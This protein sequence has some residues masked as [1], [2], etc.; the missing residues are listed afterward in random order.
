MTVVIH[1]TQGIDTPDL[2]ITGSGA[3][4]SGDFSGIPDV[5]DRVVFQTSVVNG[6][7]D[8]N[9]MPNGTNQISAFL[10]FNNSAD[11]NNSSYARIGIDNAAANISSH[12]TGSATLLPL[13]FNVGGAEQM[14]IATDGRVGIGVDPTTLAAGYRFT[15]HGNALFRSQSG[16]EG[17]EIALNLPDNSATGLN[18]DVRTAT[19]SRL[20]SVIPGMN[21]I[22][23]TG[24]GGW[25]SF[26]DAATAHMVINE[27][28]SAASAVRIKKNNPTNYNNSQLELISEAGDVKLGL[29]NQGASASL[30]KC[31]R[32][33]EA[34]HFRNGSDAA[35]VETVASAFTVASDYRLKENVVP[36]QG[37]LA[38]AMQ[39]RPCIFTWKVDGSYGEGFIAHQLQEVVPIA[40]T[41]KKDAMLESGEPD[42][43]GVDA[44]K[45]VALLTAALQELAHEVDSLRMEVKMLKRAQQ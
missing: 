27:N 37:A 8:V 31:I 34:F 38:R 2:D 22:V 14:R 42:Y 26:R 23:S 35:Y 40:V 10:A 28:G 18:L 39:L 44:A 30:I 5:D 12:R 11:L 45:I 4:I 7:T 9:A 21:L 33:N 29:H 13:T 36:M 3:R 19:E 16:G 32:G 1:G 20:F 15:V 43:Q 6:N 17:G 25:I 24:S 41:G